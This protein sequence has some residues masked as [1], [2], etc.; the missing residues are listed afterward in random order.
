MEFMKKIRLALAE[1]L[2]LIRH[3]LASLLIQ[4]PHLDL[5]AEAAN[6]YQLLSRLQTNAADL[7][8]L[9]TDLSGMSCWE[10]AKQLKQQH[11]S[12]RVLLLSP[13][14]SGAQEELAARSGI[15]CLLGKSCKPNTLFE[16]I[17]TVHRTG[18]FSDDSMQAYVSRVIHEMP[19]DGLSEKEKQI[20]RLLCEGQTNKEIAVEMGLSP[21]T[22]DFHRGKIYQKTGAANIAGLIRYALKRKLICVT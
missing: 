4:D 21:S 1:E 5:V 3:S 2:T 13:Q 16:A 8:L 15:N 9:D 17:H 20:T 7:V 6:G 14:I 10:A 22:I 18:H 12:T 19:D 11:P